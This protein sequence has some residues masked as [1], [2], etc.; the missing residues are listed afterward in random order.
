[1]MTTDA[2]IVDGVEIGRIARIDASFLA[3]SRVDNERLSA[4]T[5]AIAVSWLRRLWSGYH[6]RQR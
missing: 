6:V 2:V 5:E 3:W 1:M 4:P